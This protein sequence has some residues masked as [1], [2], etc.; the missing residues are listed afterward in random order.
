MKPLV[1]AA[2][3]DGKVYTVRQSATPDG[4]IVCDTTDGYAL[5]RLAAGRY[6]IV[7]TD[8]VLTSDD[9]DAC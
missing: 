5:A 9:P 2:D 3:A 7:G 8:T 6:Q 4:V 1:T